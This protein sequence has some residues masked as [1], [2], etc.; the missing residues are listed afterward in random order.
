MKKGR[1]NKG[2]CA[3]NIAAPVFWLA[4]PILVKTN[5][6]LWDLG[7]TCSMM[8]TSEYAAFTSFASRQGTVSFGGIPAVEWQISVH[9]ARM[10]CSTHEPAVQRKFLL[11]LKVLKVAVPRLNSGR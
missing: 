5:L 8:G 7:S 1:T 2:Y 6:L 3:F 4:Q 10:S 11:V 9:D